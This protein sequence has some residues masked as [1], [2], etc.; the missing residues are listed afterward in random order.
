MAILVVDDDREL[1]G[2]IAKMLAHA[3]L[4]AEFAHRGDIGLEQARTGRY[5]LV[6]LD[7]MM[8]G[9]DGFEVLRQLR[10]THNIPV[11][12]LSARGDDMDRVV[13]LELGADDYLPKPFHPKELIARI[14][15]VLRRTEAPPAE[16][17]ELLRAGSIALDPATRQATCGGEQLDLTTTEFDLLRVLVEA[18]GRVL[19]RDY[20]LERLSGRAGGPYDRAIDM[21]VSHLRKKLGPCSAQIVTVRG[22]GY[23]FAARA[24]EAA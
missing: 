5:A 18:A 20:L 9:I 17:G 16:A 23:Q 19:S 22:V 11:I 12:M 21:H 13:G 4:V 7:V 3:G 8:P 2:L 6:V 24:G 15:A 1:C 14:R 10:K